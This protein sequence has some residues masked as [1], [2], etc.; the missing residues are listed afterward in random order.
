MAESLYRFGAF[1]LDMATRVLWHGTT[2][3][4]LPPK[5]LDCIGYLVEQRQ[6][7]VGR[8][9]LIAAVW[10][11]ADLSDNALAQAIL[12]ARRALRDGTTGEAI[13]TV[14]RFG[15]H[16][17]LPVSVESAAMPAADT[18]PPPAAASPADAIPTLPVTAAP[19]AGP[20]RR[21]G[22][23]LGLAAAA[24]VLLAILGWTLGRVAPPPPAPPPAVAGPASDV[25]VLPARVQAGSEHGWMRLGVMDLVAGRLRAAGQAVVP[26]DNVV[27]L[28]QRLDGDPAEP[29]A[30]AELLRLT[31]AARAV[32]VAAETGANGWVV[33]LVT[34]DG[35]QPP[36]SAVGQAPDVLDAA[37][38]AA[39]QFA[40][41]SGFQPPPTAADDA[42]KAFA[43]LIQQVEAELLAGRL[44]AA[45]QR[46]ATASADQRQRPEV[47]HQMAQ[48]DFL[49]GRLDA[50]QAAWDTLLGDVPATDTP[51]LRAKIHNGLS[52]LA[53]VRGDNLAVIAQAQAAVRALDGANA[54]FELGRALIGLASGHGGLRRYDEALADYAQARVAFTAAGDRLALARVDAYQ[55]LL[56]ISRGRPADALP[57]LAGAAERLQAFHA[58]IEELHTRVGLVYAHLALLQPAQALA[59]NARLA[60]LGERVGDPR[61]RHYADLARARGLA[62][63]G[64]LAEAQAI[65]DALE[66]TAAAEPALLLEQTRSW[67]P[68]V[69]G[70]L[71][72]VRDDAADAVIQARGALAVTDEDDPIE[73][74]AAFLL[75]W[76]ALRQAGLDAEAAQVA[77]AAATWGRQR[78][79]AAARIRL[80]LIEADGAVA[81]GDDATAEAAFERALATADAYRVPAD[82]LLAAN[83]YARHLIARGDHA[84]A[85]IV[86]GR[87]AAWAPTDF[88]AALLQVALY[89]AIG[90]PGAWLAALESTRTLAGERRIPP[91]LLAPPPATDTPVPE[92][93]AVARGDGLQMEAAAARR[94]LATAGR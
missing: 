87:V 60:E 31:G 84:R 24:A 53:Y 39:D 92:P 19:P 21:A 79:H 73:R 17:S 76:R 20:R 33:A 55:G 89:R 61:R 56:D 59:Q 23:R 67:L 72:L 34:A 71:A 47:R 91:A 32:S 65:V 69:A 13:R 70:Q 37:R 74:A 48:I 81:A 36:V 9:E 54:P 52:N 27:A 30:L 25:L 78:D 11:K 57:V 88:D 41:A 58:L 38:Q 50:A 43:A 22:L 35:R 66:A 80:A 6:R 83:A 45:R 29:A 28:A 51:V 49:Q 63:T 16:W 42:E 77:Q 82:L 10:G 18:A 8:D 93:P 1:H 90:Q 68:L 85:S 12:Q 44:D 7:A 62:A 40:R 86:A 2:P 5:A 75:N 64:H 94:H 3:V 26:S 14:P 15:Y 4:A 46:L